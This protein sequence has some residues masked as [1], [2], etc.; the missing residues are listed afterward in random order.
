MPA[1]RELVDHNRAAAALPAD[2][3]QARDREDAAARDAEGRPPSG[4]QQEVDVQSDQQQADERERK[5]AV[6][7]A[8]HESAEPPHVVGWAGRRLFRRSK[9][10]RSLLLAL[11]GELTRRSGRA[12]PERTGDCPSDDEHTLTVELRRHG[13]LL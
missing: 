13:R 1:T 2:E 5:Q 10:G 6:Q 8:A 11:C 7:A 12:G 3:R 9:L 4:G